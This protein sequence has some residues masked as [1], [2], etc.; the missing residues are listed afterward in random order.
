MAEMTSRQRWLAVLNRQ[1]PDRVPMDYWGT[2][3]ITRK[4]MDYL[5][6]ADLAAMDEILHIDRPVYVS[7][8]Y[9]GPPVAPDADEYGCRFEMMDY[10][11]GA[12]RECVYHPL[13]QYATVDEIAADY[14]W[15]SADWFDYTTIPDQIAAHPD[16]PIQLNMAGVYTLYTRL[17]G[18]EQAFVDFAL[19]HDIVLYC[20]NQLYGMHHK[21]A[22]GGFE[23]GC[24][25]ID[26][27]TVHN[28]LG[29][30]LDLLCSPATVRKLFVP[31]IRRLAELAHAYGAFVFL[32]SDGAIRKAIPDLIEAGVDI[33]NPIQWRCAGMER[34]GL[35]RDFG[36]QLILHGGVDNQQTLAYGTVEDVREE[37]R[38]NIDVLGR[39]GGYILAPCHALQAI[40]PP[41]N[42][43]AMYE[44]G[45]EHGR[46]L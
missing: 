15:P 24:G 11:T 8:A 6:V 7:P 44:A 5:G 46:A 31:G 42:V 45:Y 12:Y 22:R 28:D 19:N 25:R 40:S 14:V 26:I 38:Y 39:D 20:M 34:Q 2:P 10:G 29:S 35:K 13:A 30:Q 23:A 33:L 27:G 16:Q 1:E 17:R 3:E 4:V 21:K 37:V 36:E 32:H 41:E 18:M 9:V 43:V